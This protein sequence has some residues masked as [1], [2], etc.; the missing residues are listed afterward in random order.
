M[1][2][3]TTWAVMVCLALPT[4]ATAG[5][6]FVPLPRADG[7]ASALEL[8]VVRYTGG[9]SGK[10]IVDVRNVG[11][12]PEGFSA[13]G[14]YFVPDKAAEQP[15][16]REGAAGPFVARSGRRMTTVVV[17][18]KATVRL[19]LQVFCLD[20]DRPSPTSRTSF[21]LAGRRLPGQLAALIETGAEAIL[22]RQAGR[23]GLA[24]AA[25]QSHVWNVRKLHVVQ[26]EGEQPQQ[27]RAPASRPVEAFV[28]P[29]P[30]NDVDWR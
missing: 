20:Y 16:Q 8:R 30:G 18:A 2:R 10:M 3:M 26:L 25:V 21:K 29:A 11:S 14:L 22:R 4:A 7:E 6:R 27:H 15:P 24:T 5:T 17:A 1:T 12:E 28:R 13:T 9:V 19:N 23:A